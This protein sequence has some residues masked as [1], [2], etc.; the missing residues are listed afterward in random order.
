[1]WQWLKGWWNGWDRKGMPGWIV[2]GKERHW[3]SRMLHAVVNLI[4]RH[5]KWGFGVA[6]IVVGLWIAYQKN[7]R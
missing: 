7:G 5:F 1:M 6:L 3:T 2:L 4:H